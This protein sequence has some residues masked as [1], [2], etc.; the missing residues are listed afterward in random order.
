R[1][2]LLDGDPVAGRLVGDDLHRDTAGQ[3]DRLRV[4]GPV[5]RRDD[6][7]VARVEDR[8]EGLVD[9]LLAAVGHQDLGRVD[10]VAGVAQRLRGDGGLQ[11]GE[12]AGRRVAVVLRVRA[13]LDGGLDDVVRGREV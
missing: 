7:L 8:G 4:R 9:R 5:R 13:G 10:L 11:L 1:L 6:D 3:P 2:Q 12:A